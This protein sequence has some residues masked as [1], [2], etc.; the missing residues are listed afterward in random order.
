[1]KS[2]DTNVWLFIQESDN[3][4]FG[5]VDIIGSKRVQHLRPGGLFEEEQIINPLLILASVNI[6]CLL[7]LWKNKFSN[8]NGELGALQ[9]REEEAHYF[10][11]LCK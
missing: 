2:S 10:C 11:I 9:D 3:S 5:G 4:N 7:K 6:V 8:A 1:M